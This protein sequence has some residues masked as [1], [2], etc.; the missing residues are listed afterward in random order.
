MVG[1]ATF[2]DHKFT[3]TYAQTGPEHARISYS[4][5]VYHMTDLVR[6]DAH[7]GKAFEASGPEVTKRAYRTGDE[8]CHHTYGSTTDQP[9]PLMMYPVPLSGAGVLLV[10]YY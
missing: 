7:Y 10:Y 8:C 3:I 2:S 6:V 5:A 9:F 1:C 4:S